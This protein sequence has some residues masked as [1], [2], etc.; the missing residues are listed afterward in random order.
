M[1]VSHIIFNN[2]T[3]CILRVLSDNRC[4]SDLSVSRTTHKRKHSFVMNPEWTNMEV[5]QNYGREDFFLYHS[6]STNVETYHNRIN[7]SAI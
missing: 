5:N 3:L 2:I 7:L 4:R 6:S 1:E